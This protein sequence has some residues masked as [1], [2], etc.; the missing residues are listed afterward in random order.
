MKTLEVEKIETQKLP[1]YTEFETKYK[2]E[3]DITVKF[4]NL[5]MSFA[6][7]LG[8]FDFIYVEGPDYYYTR[9]GG[10]AI[11]R[12][13]KAIN[14]K[15][16]WWTV[17]IKRN[18]KNNINRTETNWRVDGTPYETIHEGA[19]NMGWDFNFRIY[20]MCHIYK[21]KD[22]TFVLYSVTDDADKT[23][24]FM[25]IELDE[26]SIH[27]LTEEEAWDRIRKYESMLEPLGITHR[28]RLTKSLFE[29]YR[30]DIYVS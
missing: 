9:N 30:K 19:V 12:Y 29:M 8:N 21:F 11:G 17:K 20:K 1:K 27:N 6:K 10:D 3:N 13:R 14:G 16:A 23:N 2:I 7:E 25:E 15:E 22:V 24:Q 26:D 18:N 5:V 4:K 28:N